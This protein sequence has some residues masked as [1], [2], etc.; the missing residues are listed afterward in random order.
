MPENFYIYKVENGVISTTPLAGPITGKTYTYKEAQDYDTQSITYIVSGKLTESQFEAV[1]SNTSSVTIAGYNPDRVMDF[2][3]SA[4]ESSSYDRT[5]QQNNYVNTIVLSNSLSED[6]AIRKS[7]L[8]NNPTF[9]LERINADETT[10]VVGTLKFGAITENSSKDICTYNC[11]ITDGAHAKAT[12]VAGVTSNYTDGNNA[13]VT[14]GAPACNFTDKFSASTSLNEQPDSYKYRLTYVGND[15]TVYSN[16]STV[17]IHK[18]THKPHLVKYT[19][20]EISTDSDHHLV[21][22]NN[23]YITFTVSNKPDIRDYIVYRDNTIVAKAQ[24]T[25]QGTYALLEPTTDGKLNN[26][27]GTVSFTNN[28]ATEEV[29]VSDK[30]Y[31]Y[32]PNN[33]DKIVYTVVIESVRTA[34]DKYLTYGSDV[35][36]LPYA[37]VN[38]SIDKTERNTYSYRINGQTMWIYESTCSINGHHT[39]S[40]LELDHYG[41]WRGLDASDYME[42]KR[43]DNDEDYNFTEFDNNEHSATVYDSFKAPSITNTGLP[44]SYIVR[45]YTKTLDETPTYIIR[46]AITDKMIM[47]NLPT[48]VAGID[49]SNDMAVYPTIATDFIHIKY[50]SGV[51]IFNLSGSMVMNVENL[52]AIG[53]AVNVSELPAGYYVIS[54]GNSTTKFIKK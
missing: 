23:N 35:K 19:A 27:V 49:S 37:D 20:A 7:H 41:L 26:N 30:L 6:N 32:T 3:I 31:D 51:K 21:V 2:T 43:S 54:N 47:P 17:N 48:S 44:I 42:L 28:Q 10:T 15:K 36:E 11:T 22:D 16:I 12:A 9:T 14:F 18:T 1:Y 38:Y 40:E 53:N 39:E 46:E 34:N 5:K 29:T 33:T 8:M 4:T 13:I 25:Q 45:Q 52:P 24:H 50:N